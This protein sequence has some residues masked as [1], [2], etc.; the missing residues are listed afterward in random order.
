MKTKLITSDSFFDEEN[1]R[2]LEIGNSYAIL[3]VDHIFFFIMER[4]FVENFLYTITLYK[5]GKTK[6]ILDSMFSAK[7]HNSKEAKEL[8]NSLLEQLVFKTQQ[9]GILDLTKG[10]ASYFHIKKKRSEYTKS[11]LF[12]NE[13]LLE[14]NNENSIGFRLKTIGELSKSAQHFL[15]STVV[16][17]QFYD[18][19]SD[20]FPSVGIEY[21]VTDKYIECGYGRSSSFQDSTNIAQLEAVERYCSIY[22]PYRA[23]DIYGK[24]SQLTNAIHPEICILPSSDKN[25][26]TP[27]Q[28]DLEIY[29]TEAESLKNK[30]TVL[31]PEQLAIYGDSFFRDM[32]KQHRFIYDSSNGVAL[33]ASFEEAVLYGLLELIERD[34]FLTTWYG[35]I[36]VDEVTIDSLGLSND[37]LKTINRFKQDSFDVR[38]FDISME[39]GVPSF[40]AL[41]RNLKA[42]KMYAYTAAG[43][44][45]LPHKAA[46]SALLE[47][48][49]GIQ[50]HDNMNT[51]FDIGI[52]NEVNE[53]KDHV[54]YYSSCQ[55]RAAFDFL[56]TSH[57]ITL[58]SQKYISEINTKLYL[59]ELIQ[60]I[61]AKY[62]DI[63][64]VNLTS[65]EME[66][67]GLYTVKVIVPG[68]IPMTFGVQNERVSLNR[69]NRE[70]NRRGLEEV[71]VINLY[72]HPFP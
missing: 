11:P 34:N 49:V 8:A 43:S 24:F 22:Y 30:K 39:L 44:N 47:A 71:R 50:I 51:K 2:T 45:P 20:Y 62:E 17:H 64:V 58:S 37:I 54:N 55:H 57:V 59:K 61:L 41:I 12:L 31:I 13:L 52:P 5:K 38:I 53:M 67:L 28:N 18:L 72:P 35:S 23:T 4:K 42:N 26:F 68:F 7:Y 15:D 29:W 10:N 60:R 69:I 36:P 27:Y 25:P 66:E 9:V 3:V 46:E 32:E 1:M 16:Y 19:N 63:Y 40:W 33:G 70:R 14:E 65:K 6:N 56:N 48:F 21:A